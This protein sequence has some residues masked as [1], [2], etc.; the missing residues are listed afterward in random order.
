T[1]RVY[2]ER[3][4]VEE[5]PGQAVDPRQDLRGNVIWSGWIRQGDRINISSATGPI[6]YDY[7]YTGDDRFHG[8]QSTWCNNGSLVSVP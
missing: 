5:R 2:E 4:V 3:R 8:D 7:R 6:R 1:G